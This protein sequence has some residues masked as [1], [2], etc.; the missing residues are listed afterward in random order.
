MSSRPRKGCSVQFSAEDGADLPPS[1]DPVTGLRFT[2]VTSDGG[3]VLINY[4]ALQP[5]RLALAFARALRHMASPAG[6]LGVRSTVKAYA[7]TLPKFFAYLAESSEPISGPE[8]LRASHID[9]FE[10]WLEGR[11]L[12]R[13]HLFTILVKLVGA[14]RVIAA[15]R[16]SSISAD[17]QHRLRYVSAK[18]YQRSAPRDAYSPYVARQLRDAARA[19]IRQIIQR[20]ESGPQDD[21]E[22]KIRT[23]ETAAHAFITEH[24]VILSSES[25]WKRLYRARVRFGRPT[26]SLTDDLHGA[27]YLGAHDVIPFLVALALETGLEIECCKTLGV[28]CLQNASGGTVDI[29]Y[30]KLRARGAEHKQ[31]RVRDNGSGTPGGLIRKLITLT[32]AA[33]HHLPVENIWVY[34]REAAL[35]AGIKHSQGLIDA[36]INRHAI[37]DDH[38]RPLQ[39]L[40]SRLRKTH[41]ALWYLK[42]EGH[43]ARFAVGHTPEVAAR[44]YANIPSLR[45]LHE[46]TVAN[47]LE[48]VVARALQPRVLTPEQEEAWLLD[49]GAVAGL[50]AGADPITILGGDQ[51]VWL[52]SC[53]GFYTSPFGRPGAACPTPVWGCLECSNAVI[54]AQKLPAI[55]AFLGFIEAQREGLAEDHW[56]AKFGR[57]HAR[58]TR[59]ILPTFSDEIVAQARLAARVAGIPTYLPPEISF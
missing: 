58:I 17:L 55:I 26:K 19:D 57:V 37:V 7:V 9:G 44:H 3:V 21:P 24:G 52:A 1:T 16:I 46:T 2:I 50:P 48:D 56:V 22:L 49:A 34:H 54:T 51:D 31:M 14:L 15:D 38:G 18:P 41:K 33:R 5:R 43:M 39:L 30:T 40:L 11:G 42:T 4:V 45:A 10:I 13:I 28:E 20:V 53:G 25:L 36:W 23:I 32:S 59:Q 8:D 47:A 12:T 29:A 35:V 27:H 6:S